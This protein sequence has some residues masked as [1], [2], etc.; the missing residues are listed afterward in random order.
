MLQLEWPNGRHGC[1]RHPGLLETHLVS[2]SLI[3]P[4]PFR[5]SRLVSWPSPSMSIFPKRSSLDCLH[6]FSVQ[7]F[8]LW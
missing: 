3:A 1:V 7:R 4:R 8:A 6:A 5:I 2:I